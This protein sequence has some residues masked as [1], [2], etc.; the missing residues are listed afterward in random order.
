MNL[1]NQTELL[2]EDIEEEAVTKVVE[3]EGTVGIK[4]RGK[5]PQIRQVL[6]KIF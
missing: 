6:L 2:Q 5:I 1:K 3:E 4:T